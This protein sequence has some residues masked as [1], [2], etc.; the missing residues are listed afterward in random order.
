[1]SVAAWV[2]CIQCV[3]WALGAGGPF[4]VAQALQVSGAAWV[5]SLQWVCGAVGPRG[6]CRAASVFWKHGRGWFLVGLQGHLQL[7]DLKNLKIFRVIN[8]C[9]ILCFEIMAIET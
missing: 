5:S 4:W 8:I 3:C 7:R 2:L 1:M 9:I 6:T